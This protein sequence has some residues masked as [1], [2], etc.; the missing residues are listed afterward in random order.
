M[1][2]ISANASVNEPK[3]DLKPLRILE[4]V[5]NAQ[6]K[7]GLRHENYQRYRG[8]CGRRIERIRK[9]LKFTNQYKCLPKR[10]GKFVS[11]KVTPELVEDRRYLEIV[12]FEVERNWAY[13]MQY[14]F[15]AI[16]E[17]LSR[18]KF[19]M[20]QKLRKAVKWVQFLDSL[21]EDN[22]MV[23]N[24]TKLETKGYSAFIHASLALELKNWKIAVEYFESASR[25]YATL[26]EQEIGEIYSA[27]CCEV[28]NL[29]KL[30]RSESGDANVLLTTVSSLNLNASEIEE[31]RNQVAM[32]TEE[33][34]TQ[35][36]PK[37]RNDKK[38]RKD[39]KPVKPFFFDI[40]QNFLQT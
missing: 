18:K 17:P 40:A 26:F 21:V 4:L 3:P 12:V 35:T 30:C 36:T 1:H 22:E 32:D 34:N 13:A 8:Y 2:S 7:H 5:K 29:L 11:R 33:P 38:L 6:Q 9:S 20:R 16:N 23:Q 25:D 28:E 24:V 37:T 10:T 39:P 15:E 19:V 31:K 14:K 27:R